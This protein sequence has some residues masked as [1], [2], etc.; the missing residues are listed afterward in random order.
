M[1]QGDQ[2]A[3][4]GRMVAR[5][6]EAKKRRA[7]L[8]SEARAVGEKLENAGKTLKELEYVKAFWDGRSDGQVR[9]KAD[10]TVNAYPEA[11]RANDLIEE[12]R[13][14]AAEIRQLREQM[15]DA[16]LSVE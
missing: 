1:T 4:I 13:L 8:M 14:V 16:G 11:E 5:Y 12:L 3:A 6:S 7:A 9:Q 10:A 2:D 15:K